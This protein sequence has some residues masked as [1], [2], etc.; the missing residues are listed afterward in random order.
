MVTR[1]FPRTVFDVLVA[2]FSCITIS[3]NVAPARAQKLG[4]IE[5]VQ[6]SEEK[7]ESLAEKPSLTFH[8]ERTPALTI[9]VDDTVKYQ[10]ID[11]FGA[12]LT[13]SSAWLLKRKLTDAQRSEAVRMLFDR[14]K[15]IGLS[16]LRQPMGASDF[17][18]R[19]YSYDEMPAGETDP[20]LKKFS[21][22]HD[23]ADILPVLK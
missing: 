15:G 3:M 12:S 11:G 16:M 23:R 9:F 14:Q 10:E 1:P 17:A 5:V 21:I 13:E 19:E 22:D 18:L 6:S 7:H 8:A 20:E 4:E 2:L